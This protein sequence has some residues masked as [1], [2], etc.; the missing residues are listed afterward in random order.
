MLTAQIRF[1]R[2][3]RSIGRMLLMLAEEQSKRGEN[4]RAKENYSKSVAAYDK[5]LA[6][7]TLQPDAWFS[8]GCAASRIDDYATAARAFRRKVDIDADVRNVLTFIPCSIFSNFRR[9]SNHG[10][11]WR[12]HTSSSRTSTRHFSHSRLGEHGYSNP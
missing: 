5:S 9:I 1:T 8:M 2:A 4:D 6:L 3:M 10:T 11:I 7:N 12:M